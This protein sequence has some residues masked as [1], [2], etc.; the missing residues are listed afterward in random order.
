MK[1]MKNTLLIIFGLLFLGFNLNAGDNKT[2]KTGKFKSITNKIDSKLKFE[3]W[4]IEPRCFDATE[5][6][7]KEE[8]MELEKW[9]IELKSYNTSEFL[10]NEEQMILEKWMINPF[11][12]NTSN[13][14]LIDKPL[15]LEKWMIK[16]F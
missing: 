14:T 2:K 11:S 8:L 1:T 15:E 7:F 12:S 13:K 16:S 4:M 9:M 5:L 10:L 3:K 6:S